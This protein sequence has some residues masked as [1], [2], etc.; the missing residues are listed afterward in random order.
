MC[1]NVDSHGLVAKILVKIHENIR[2]I[3]K[4]HETLR[5][6]LNAAAEIYIEGKYTTSGTNTN[7]ADVFLVMRLKFITYAPFVDYI[8]NGNRA[9][10]LMKLNDAGKQELS[11]IDSILMK[12][13]VTSGNKNLPTTLNSLLARPFQHIMRYQIK[14]WTQ[15]HRKISLICFTISLN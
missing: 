7:L 2:P 8:F 10:S 4:L 5:E 1:Q 11:I 3:Y 14:Y 12:K 13:S 6:K 9:I 15:I